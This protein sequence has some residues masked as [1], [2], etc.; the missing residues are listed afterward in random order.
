MGVAIINSYLVLL[1]LLVH[2]KIVPINFK[3]LR[4][5]GLRTDEFV[6]R[7]ADLFGSERLF[8]GSD[9]TNSVGTHAQLISEGAAAAELL[10]EDERAAFLGGTTAR[11]YG[12]G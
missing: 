6:R 11:L 4:E 5:A 8:F 1:F 9:V 10:D 3:F 7:A 12:I 2:F